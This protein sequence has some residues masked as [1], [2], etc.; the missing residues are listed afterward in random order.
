MLGTLAQIIALVTYGN[1]ALRKLPGFDFGSFYPANN[2]FLFC[3]QVCFVRVTW[4][5]RWE[6][7]EFA[8]DPLAWLSGLEREG[9][10]GLRLELAPRLDRDEEG[11]EAPERMLA[12]FVGGGARWR[13]E[14]WMPKVSEFWEAHWKVGDRERED[15]R[16]WNVTYGQIAS[17]KRK[18]KSAPPEADLEALKRDL[19]STLEE[20][21]GF[22]ARQRLGNFAQVFERARAL[23]DAPEPLRET[24]GF[25]LAPAGILSLPAAQLLCAAQAAWVFGGMGS[26]NDQSFA[27]E[28]GQVYDRLSE[29]LYQR[30]LTAFPAAVNTGDPP[31]S[32]SS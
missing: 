10:L 31:V 17:E 9:L 28:D 3:E 24:R 6:E 2:T 7:E 22:A 13:I 15:Q 5:M 16:I 8:A 20:I 29:Q 12:G 18:K 23:L 19:G 27:G 32:K 30:L 4:G 14:A 26:W 11:D 1:A 25:D 21:A